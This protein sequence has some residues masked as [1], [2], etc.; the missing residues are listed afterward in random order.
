MMRLALPPA[1]RVQAREALLEA[2]ELLCLLVD[3]GSDLA[4]GGNVEKGTIVHRV[5]LYQCSTLC[6]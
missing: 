3:C 5:F 1:S 4:K 2:G 6:Q